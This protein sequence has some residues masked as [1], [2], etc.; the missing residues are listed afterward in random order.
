MKYTDFDSGEPL[1]SLKE[2]NDLTS[3]TAMVLAHAVKNNTDEFE[4]D[5]YIQNWCSVGG[6]PTEVYVHISSIVINNLNSI[7]RNG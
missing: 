1:F 4:L 7:R 2:V 3:F 6:Y 5:V